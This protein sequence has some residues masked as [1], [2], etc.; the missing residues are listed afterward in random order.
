MKLFSTVGNYSMRLPLALAFMAVA[1]LRVSAQ[2][3]D[4]LRLGMKPHEAASVYTALRSCSNAPF[5]EGPGLMGWEAPLY[6]GY[7]SI[8]IRFGSSGAETLS[9]HIRPSGGADAASM[10]AA[11]VVDR[12]RAHG[13]PSA[14]E[15]GGA[16]WILPEGRLEI[17]LVDGELHIELSVR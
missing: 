16:L 3:P 2:E 8:E 7:A 9:Y 10:F 15:G 14:R 17:Q 5:T 12:T 1:A 11:A 13:A 6:G 4:Y